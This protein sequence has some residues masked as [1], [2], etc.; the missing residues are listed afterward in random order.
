MVNLA[1]RVCKPGKCRDEMALAALGLTGNRARVVIDA[2]EL[3]LVHR[4]GARAVQP[5]AGAV[6]QWSL[7]GR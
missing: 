2:P 5:G 3:A 6:G 4:E 7:D 1:A